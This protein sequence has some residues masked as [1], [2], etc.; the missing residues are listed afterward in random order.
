[1]T[2]NVYLG[3]TMTGTLG[4][5]LDASKGSLDQVLNNHDIAVVT[6][7]RSDLD[8][9]ERKWW[10]YRSGCLV[11]TYTDWYGEE[12]IISASPISSPA[13]EDRAAGTVTLE[14]TGLGRIFEDR[15][16]VDETTFGGSDWKSKP[17]AYRGLSFS[18]LCANILHQGMQ[19]PNGYLP[20]DLP[21]RTTKGI[22]GRTY[23][24]WNLA[25][26]ECWK[27]VEEITEVIGGPDVAFRAEWTDSTRTAWRWRFVAGTDAQMTLPQDDEPF[28]DATVPGT[29]VKSIEVK[30]EADSM[31]HKSYVVGSGEG[32]GISAY[33]AKSSRISPDMPFIEHVV[34]IPGEESENED[35]QPIGQKSPVLE[36]AARAEVKS[37]GT[38]QLD[39]VVNADGVDGFPIGTWNVGELARLKTA[40][41]LQVPDGEYLLRIVQTKFNITT[42]QVTVSCQEDQLGKDYTW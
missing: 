12:R 21:S 23:E 31:A 11:I 6:V 40:G 3:L 39:V 37:Q 7:P 33:W 4:Q 28:W 18:A 34:A 16:V 17:L 5:R 30:S 9:V 15:L 29:V 13:S 26:N 24:A 19:K 25:N 10:S 35:G 20:L 2:W 32:A 1:M 27:R 14:G 42:S 8:G 38:D 41:W 22:H 36:A